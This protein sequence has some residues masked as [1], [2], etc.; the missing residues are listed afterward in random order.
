MLPRRRGGEL[1][2]SRVSEGIGRK[3]VWAARG[4]RAGGRHDRAGSGKWGLA[5]RKSKIADMWRGVG[6]GKELEG[7]AIGLEGGTV[8][9]RIKEADKVECGV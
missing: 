4:R 2:G 6:S 1:T 9:E 5:E 8:R 7:T 3:R